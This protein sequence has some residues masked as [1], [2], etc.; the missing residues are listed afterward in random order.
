MLLA[1]LHGRKHIGGVSAGGNTDYY[2]FGSDVMLFAEGPPAFF[3]VVFGFFKV[4][5]EVLVATGKHSLPDFRGDAVGIGHFKD[6]QNGKFAAGA[7]TQ[8]EEAAACTD[9]RLDGINKFFNVRKHRLDGEGNFLVFGVDV[10]Q[11]FSYGLLFQMVVERRLLCKS[12]CHKF[13]NIV[14]I[15]YILLLQALFRFVQPPQKP[16]AGG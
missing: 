7:G 1:G 16:S 13:P 15:F 3:G 6:V 11:Q 14:K 12:N 2:I 8:P 9:L 10:A 5:Y 4:Q